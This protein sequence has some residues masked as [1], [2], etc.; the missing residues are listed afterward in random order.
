M[1]LSYVTTSQ[2]K[3]RLGVSDTVDDTVIGTI[4]DQVNGFIESYCHRAVGPWATGST[5]T[6]HHWPDDGHDSGRVFDIPQ[7]ISSLTLLEVA[8]Y[9]GASFVSVPTADV[10][11]IPAA[12]ERD[13]GWPATEVHMSDVPS[14]SN[15][16][17][18]FSRGYN[19]VRITG[20]FGWTAIPYEVQEVAVNLAL[21]L[22][23]SRSAG[24]SDVFTIGPDGER[25]FERAMSDKDRRTLLRYQARTVTIV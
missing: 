18:F 19:T 14:A 1:A 6:F 17:P 11:L 25:T 21:A 22:W 2:V 3:A 8:P 5:F 16:Q 4:C 12:Q 9:T 13:E 24:T 15:G 23:R 20:N 10:F 7:G